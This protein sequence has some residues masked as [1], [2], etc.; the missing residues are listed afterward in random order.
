MK[1]RTYCNHLYYKQNPVPAKRQEPG[2]V[3]STRQSLLEISA[4]L[5][6]KYPNP[7]QTGAGVNT[8][9]RADLSFH[10]DFTFWD[11]CF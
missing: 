2:S 1:Q 3:Y 8:E 7:Q 10:H 11:A 9:R 6:F 5:F 4:I